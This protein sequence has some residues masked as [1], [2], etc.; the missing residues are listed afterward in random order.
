MPNGTVEKQIVLVLETNGGE[1]SGTEKLAALVNLI[2]KKSWVRHCARQL[3]KF[4]VI[5]IRPS[6]GGRGHQTVY[7]QNRNQPGQPRK[8]R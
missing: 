2:N 6:R 7:K 4:G 8:T 3:A 5:T 1:V